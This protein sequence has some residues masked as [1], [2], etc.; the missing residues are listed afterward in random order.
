M[1]DTK[2]DRTF[3]IVLTDGN[4]I[5]IKASGLEW[6]EKSRTIRLTKGGMAVARINMDN[7][8]GWIDSKNKQR[9]GWSQ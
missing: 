5:N 4:I 3:S 7:V 6:C 2:M 1:T 9:E 8:V